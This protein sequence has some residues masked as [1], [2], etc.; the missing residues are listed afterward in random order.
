MVIVVYIVIYLSINDCQSKILYFLSKRKNPN[1]DYVNRS[2][3]RKAENQKVLYTITIIV[4][5]DALFWFGICIAFL[6]KWYIYDLTKKKSRDWYIN[7]Q[8]IFQSVM[9][10]LIPLNSIINPFVYFHR[11]WYS[12]IKKLKT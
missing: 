8:R 11:F 12:V 2:Q 7:D 5:T 4:L 3:Q 9:F 1:Q 10:Y 6:S